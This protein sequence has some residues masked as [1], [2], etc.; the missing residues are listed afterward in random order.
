MFTIKSIINRGEYLGFD[1]Q[2]GYLYS[3]FVS[4]NEKGQPLYSIY[5]IKDGEA[6]L[7]ITYPIINRKEN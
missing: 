5:A 3:L 6:D 7:L 1:N 2:K 4:Y